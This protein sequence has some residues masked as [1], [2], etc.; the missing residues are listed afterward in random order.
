MTR[1]FTR[2]TLVPLKNQ[3]C[4]FQMHQMNKM[5]TTRDAYMSTLCTA[6][7]SIS[8][9][10]C[11]YLYCIYL[12]IRLFIQ[13]TLSCIHIGS[14]HNGDTPDQAKTITSS[15]K[16]SPIN[17]PSAQPAA[18]CLTTM[19]QYERTPKH[20]TDH[21]SSLCQTLWFLT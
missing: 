20:N 18:V 4:T 21:I 17:Q 9:C 13:Y 10:I 7:I 8:I 11:F 16:T 2:Q 19:S 12:F 14:V 1:S 5:I 6:C 15:R 3:I